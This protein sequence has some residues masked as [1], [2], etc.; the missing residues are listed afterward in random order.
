[1]AQ[2]RYWVWLS[3]LQGLRP[4]A[5]RRVL[6]HFS[7]PMEAYYAP[8]DGFLSVPDLTERERALLDRRDLGRAEEILEICQRENIRILTL[9]DAQYPE[10]LRQIPDPPCVLYIRGNLPFLDELP[11][12]ALVGTRKASAYG[13]KMALRLGAEITAGGGLVVTGLALGIDGAAARGALSAGGGCVG[14]LGTAINVD[15]PAANAALIGDVAAVGAV[16]S[17]FP[18]LWPT[19]PENFPRRNRIISGL[20]CGTCVVEAPAR[21][22]AL[23]TANLA[24]DQGRDLFAVPGNAD[25]P[26]STGTNGLLRDCAKAVTRGWDILEEYEGLFPDRLREVKAPEKAPE[27]MKNS[28]AEGQR[29]IDKQQGIPYIDLESRL[30]GYSEDQKTMLRLLWKG[31]AQVDEL[32]ASTGF[33]TAKVL[34]ELTMLTIRG[35]VKFLPGKRYTLNLK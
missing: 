14:V 9:Q 29:P 5:V 27:T 4:L 15:Y 13:I 28:P 19:L 3:S 33:S 7:D 34:S 8:A 25:S 22:G 2:L 12:I 10:R 11:A 30:S 26:L 31:D 24:L 18:P 20:C 17:E 6:E 32:I 1:M 16:I 35:A 23:I 21:S